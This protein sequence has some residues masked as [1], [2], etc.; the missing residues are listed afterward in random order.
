MK[1][2]Q[3]TPEVIADWQEE[4]TSQLAAGWKYADVRRHLTRS[5]CTPEL[6]DQ[7]MRKAK[8]GMLKGNRKAGRVALVGG[9]VLLLAGIAIVLV[10]VLLLGGGSVLVPGGMI[11]AGLVSIATG[12]LKAVF[13]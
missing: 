11:L 3:I 13:G 2:V 9:I 8:G 1:V 12:M 4:A 6:T 10:Q 7:I 5:G